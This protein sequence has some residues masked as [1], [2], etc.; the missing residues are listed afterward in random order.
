VELVR[1]VSLALDYAHDQGILHRDIK[2][3]NIMLKPDPVEGLPFRPVIT[4][5][6]LAKLLEGQSLTQE[7]TSMGTPA[8]MSPEQA[9]GRKTDARSDVYSLRILLYEL[10]VESCRSRSS[11]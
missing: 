2:P 3:G 6:G 11:P 4:D 9:M 8:Y 1:Q 5:L 10:A 7:G